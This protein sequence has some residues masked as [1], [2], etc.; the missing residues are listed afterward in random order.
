MT[1]P[2]RL[3]GSTWVIIPYL[4]HSY[5]ALQSFIQSYYQL[6]EQTKNVVVVE[7]CV[8]GSKLHKHLGDAV[9][10]VEQ[11]TEANLVKIG[12]VNLPDDCDK[13][14]WVKP[15]VIFLDNTWLDRLR[16]YLEHYRVVQPFNKMVPVGIVD[17]FGEPEIIKPEI[18]IYAWAYRRYLG[19]WHQIDGT[20]YMPGDIRYVLHR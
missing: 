8:S 19:E 18:N 7:S 4:Q 13:I 17:G 16:L 12:A 3:N 9:V 1:Y 11:T 14:V 2:K 10:K 20:S 6:E 15:G 5:E